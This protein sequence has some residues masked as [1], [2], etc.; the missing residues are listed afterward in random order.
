MKFGE[1]ISNPHAFNLVISNSCE[2]QS[3]GFDRPVNTA[4]K[5][6]L[7]SPIF[8]NFSIVIKRQCCVPNP[9]FK[10][11]LIFREFIYKEIIYLIMHNSLIHF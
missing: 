5:T 4:A 9:F 10:T 7:L 2:I 11:Q 1:F 6:P 3:K 8:L